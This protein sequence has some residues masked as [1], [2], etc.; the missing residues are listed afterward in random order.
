MGVQVQVEIMFYG[1][2]LNIAI[3]IIYILMGA[4][5]FSSYETNTTNTTNSINQ[6]NQLKKH[7]HPNQLK[8][9]NQM[10]ISL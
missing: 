1:S 7:N 9:H 6:C 8:K 4:L 10:S 5:P 2:F 3:I